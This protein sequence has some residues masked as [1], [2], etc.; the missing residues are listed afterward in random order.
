MRNLAL[1]ILSTLFLVACNTTGEINSSQAKS[2][3]EDYVEMN[4]IFET[5]K[6]NTHKMRL[7]SNKDSVLITSLQ[8]LETQGYIEIEN[9]KARKK[10]FSKDSVFVIT[11]TLT[12]K[13]FPFVVK[14]NANNT[15][16]KTI[17]FKLDEKQEINF[18]RKGK[19][20]ATFNAILL[21]EKTPFSVFGK[22][23][24]P[25]AT[26]ITKKFKAKY[27]EENGWVLEE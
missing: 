16:V 22:E 14:Q 4:P 11:P 8:Q 5:G 13:A 21:K 10:W 2:L 1:F 24:N 23:E 25:K 9:V 26:F 17:A 6:F 15:Q 20:V 27:S 7:V 12:Q 18:E 3:V 19:N